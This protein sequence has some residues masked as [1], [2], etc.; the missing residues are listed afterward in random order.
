MLNSM[1]W[2]S[3]KNFLCYLGGR[4]GWFGAKAKLVHDPVSLLS[5]RGSPPV[6]N[7]R[8]LHPDQLGYDAA[9]DLLIL[10]S[11][12]PVPGLG[13]PVC[14]RSCRVLPVPMAEEVPLIFSNLRLPWRQKLSRHT[15]QRRTLTHL[16]SSQMGRE[17]K[18]YPEGPMARICWDRHWPRLP[19]RLNRDSISCWW[20]SMWWAPRPW[21]GTGTREAT[22][23]QYYYVL[24]CFQQE[25]GTKRTA[26]KSSCWKFK[27]QWL[28]ELSKERGVCVSSSQLLRVFTYK[29]TRCLATSKGL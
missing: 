19:S 17:R 15:K 16:L 22:W 3:G 27:G 26:S 23:Y 7:Q 6:E 13:R 24:P 20:G 10:P 25:N 28:K 29:L 21:D 14:P 8:L 2:R 9:E 5:S 1:L 11:R 12:F 4:E 18:C